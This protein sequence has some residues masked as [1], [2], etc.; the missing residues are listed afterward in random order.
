MVKKLVSLNR[1]NGDSMRTEYERTNELQHYGVKG[2]KWGVRR[3][4]ELLASHRRNVAVKRATDDYNRGKLSDEQYSRKVDKAN[5]AKKDY[6]NKLKSDY[7]SA[8]KEKRQ[9][10]SDGISKQAVKE[11]PRRKIAKGASI[12]NAIITGAEL[13]TTAVGVAASIAAAPALGPIAISSLAGY[14]V[15]RL[16]RQW[17]IDRGIDKLV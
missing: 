8:S 10:I 3:D 5:K 1:L 17:L 14:S 7:E 2:M 9:Q 11:I 16:G 13:G 4:A 15:G 6:L 12:T